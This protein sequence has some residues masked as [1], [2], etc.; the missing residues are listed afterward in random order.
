MDRTPEQ[1]LADL[2]LAEKLTLISGVDGFYSQEIERLGIPRLTMADASMGLRCEIKEFEA[3][4]FPA[5]IC[6]AATWNRD[7]A[8]KY[9][10]AVADEFR[11]AGIDVLLGPGVNIYRVPQCGRNFEYM[12]EDPFL[13]AELIVPYIRAVQEVGV[14]ATVKHF[15]C[16]NTDWNRCSSNSVVDERTLREI[17]FPVFEAAVRDADVK[18]VMTSYN[19][20]NGEYAGESHLLV[21][22]ILKEEWEFSGLVMSDWDGLW[23]AVG[24]LKSGLHLEMPGGKTL[25][26]EIVKGLLDS[27]EVAEADIDRMVLGVLRFINEVERMRTPGDY[28]GKCQA[29]ADI[30]LQTAREGIVLLKNEDSMLPLLPEPGSLVVLGPNACPTPTSGGGAALVKAIDPVSIVSGMVQVASGRQ[31]L[32]DEAKVPGAAAVVVCVG[33]GPDREEEGSDRPFKLPAEQI[34]LINRCTDKSDN[35][36]VVLT[37]GGS[38]ATTGWLDGIRALVHLW[39]P[40][41]NGALALAE[42][43]FGITNPSGKLPISF[44]AEFADN[45]ASAN[46]LPAGAELYEKV[47]YQD[48]PVEQF[49]VNYAEGVFVGYR[50]YCKDKPPLFHFGHGLS[51]TDFTFSELNVSAS[52]GG[53]VKVQLSIANTGSQSGAEVAQVYI[54]PPESPVKRPRLELKGFEK[55]ALEPGETKQVTV[56]L[57]RRAFTYWCIDQHDWV[58]QPGTYK[59]HVG[60]SSRDIRLYGKVMIS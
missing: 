36:V 45:P 35:V 9:G 49:D 41:E 12:G 30:A 34:A 37:C 50:G 33:Y 31:V 53:A 46:Y 20:V 25:K 24:S 2:T 55:V 40:G 60:A 18:A 29:H 23:D 44:E 26:P 6:L 19:L 3:T 59:I 4:A 54:E 58:V 39:Y 57:P 38:V 5:S 17:Y 27:G 47:N 48:R 32:R 21:T 7:L 51:Y 52:G 15:A 56:N 13:A 1:L 11:I 28:P 8:A 16:N 14:A 22:K 42:I 10:R 43:L